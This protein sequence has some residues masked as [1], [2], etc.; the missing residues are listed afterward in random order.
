MVASHQ[1]GD[2]KL[3]WLE[4][5]VSSGHKNAWPAS[6]AGKNLIKY[7]TPDR[8]CDQIQRHKFCNDHLQDYLPL[9]KWSF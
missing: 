2:V 9:E 1:K 4:I 7:F 3:P 6:Q 8:S 5:N